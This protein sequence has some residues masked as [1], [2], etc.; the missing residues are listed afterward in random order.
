MQPHVKCPKFYFILIFIQLLKKKKTITNPSAGWCYTYE[1]MLEYTIA[2][3][4]MKCPKFYF[5][6][7]ANI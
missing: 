1:I 4:R 5:R 2:A 7:L 6:P 3:E